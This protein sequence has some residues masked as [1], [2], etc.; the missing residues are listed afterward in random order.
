[1]KVKR[2]A[3]ESASTR[4]ELSNSIR[5]VDRGDTPSRES[6]EGNSSQREN[7]IAIPTES[8]STSEKKRVPD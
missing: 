6:L 3:E 1:M 4:K 8:R 2:G 5:E 7:T